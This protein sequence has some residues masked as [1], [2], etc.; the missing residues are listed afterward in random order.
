M[1]LFIY[2]FISNLSL[3]FVACPFKRFVTYSGTWSTRGHHAY[4]VG[5][6]KLTS[7]RFGLSAS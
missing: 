1:P 3:N 7:P 6:R 5:V 4:S 2:L